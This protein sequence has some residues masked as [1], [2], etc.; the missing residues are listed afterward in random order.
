MKPLGDEPQ[1]YDSFDD[2]DDDDDGF[3][4]AFIKNRRI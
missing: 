4:P 1:T 3:P 2:D